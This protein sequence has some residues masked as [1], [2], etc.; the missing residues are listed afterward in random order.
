[1]SPEIIALIEKPYL[2]MSVLLLGAFAGM[3]I[4]KVLAQQRSHRGAPSTR[5]RSGRSHSRS[6]A[7]R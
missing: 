4:E 1:M 2:L 6:V 3:T 7:K 5:R